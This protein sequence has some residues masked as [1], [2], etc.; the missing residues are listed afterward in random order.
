MCSVMLSAQTR[1]AA[2]LFSSGAG[3]DD[4]YKGVVIKNGKKVL[5]K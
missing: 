4:S 2:V 5:K 1:E 3:M